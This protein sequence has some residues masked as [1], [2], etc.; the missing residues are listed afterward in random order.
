MPKISVLSIKVGERQ[1]RAIELAPLDELAKSFSE[2]GQIQPIVVTREMELI[3]GERRL[4]A[5]LKLG[6]TEIDA[7]IFE[8]LPEPQRQRIELEENVRRV[9][10][11]WPDYVSA[12]RKLHELYVSSDPAWT[13]ERTAT[14]LGVSRTRLAEF[15]G[16]AEAVQSTPALAKE[17]TLQAVVN[18]QRRAAARQLEVA[19]NDL[20]APAGQEPAPSLPWS[21]ETTDFLTWA[22]AYRGRPFNVIHCDFPYGLNM[23]DARMANSRQGD[24]YEDSPELYWNLVWCLLR[25]SPTLLAPSGYGLFWLSMKFFSETLEKF[26]S[27][28]DPFPA[29]WHKSDLRGIIPDPKRGG[30]RTYEAALLLRWGDPPPVVK[31]VAL[32]ISAPTGRADSEHISE[33]PL[34]VVKH[35]LSMLVDGTSEVLDPT[36]G[37]G[38]ALRAAQELGASRIVG[39]DT[40]Q[41]Y[42]DVARSKL[43]AKLPSSDPLEDL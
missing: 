25:N 35:F 8:D 23:Q 39:L 36:C 22:P 41:K 11:P 42:V 10:L 2:I 27:L 5:A 38:T 43:L 18:K 14:S 34:E 37:S 15:L 30:R 7:V 17:V 19:L 29:I 20:A 33:K 12:V 28:A 16:V 9:D 4:R 40:E 21:L 32:S 1:R 13:Q 24:R 31:N 26:G 6:W 3:A